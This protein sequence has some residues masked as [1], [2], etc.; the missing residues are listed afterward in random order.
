VTTMAPFREATAVKRS[1]RRTDGMMVYIGE[2][3]REW[4]IGSCVLLFP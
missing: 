3:D 1:E 2:V 4:M